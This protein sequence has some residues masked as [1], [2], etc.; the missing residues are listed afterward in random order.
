MNNQ[1]FF[2]VVIPVYNKG[3]H[4]LRSI[5]SVLNQTYQ[6]FEIITI[7]D[8]STDNSVEELHKFSDPRI[9][10]LHRNT[11]GPGGYAARNLGIRKAK[12]EWI[13]FLDADDEWLP[14]HLKNLEEC[15]NAF[16]SV[17][18]FGGGYRIIENCI[19]FNN[20]YYNKNA[21]KGDHILTFKEYL[22]SEVNSL[23]P[24]CTSSACINK[25]VLLNVGGFPEYS[26][27]KRGGDV[28]TWLRCAAY[29]QKICVC[30]HIGVKYYRDSVNMV[31]KTG[32]NLYPEI[33]NTVYTLLKNENSHNQKLLKKISNKSVIN[34]WRNNLSKGSEN[35]YLYQYL[36]F[37]EKPFKCLYYSFIS[38]IPNYLLIKIE[39]IV[40]F[41]F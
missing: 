13:A 2:S 34:A 4:I 9:Q 26:K 22:I 3:P 40:N 21:F 18:I 31:T 32:S 7:N 11:P 23:R 28:D 36:F 38:L 24:Y 33:P 8:A 39:N 25:K 35:I 20:S 6:N 37:S 10:T 15:I 41:K 12:Y 16:P 5:S 27:A 29:G 14:D 19:E 17:S 30:S 1:I